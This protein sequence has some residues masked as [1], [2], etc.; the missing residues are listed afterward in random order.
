M[1]KQQVSIYAKIDDELSLA[2]D[3]K[4]AAI[5]TLNIDTLNKKLG[6]YLK[7]LKYDSSIVPPKDVA[8]IIS[9]AAVLE[10]FKVEA[11]KILGEN[12]TL[13]EEKKKECLHG[14]FGNDTEYHKLHDK[15][16]QHENG[17]VARV[18]NELKAYDI[19][20]LLDNVI[21][22]T[23][24][25][26]DFDINKN[27]FKDIAVIK[28]E[29]FPS[30]HSRKNV[31]ITATDAFDKTNLQNT[32][33]SLL[34]SD[35]KKLGLL[36][37]VMGDENNKGAIALEKNKE[38]HIDLNTMSGIGESAVRCLVIAALVLSSI[39]L[40][41]FIGGTAFF[42]ITTVLPG[43]A[44]SGVISMMAF[45]EIETTVSKETRFTNC[46][47]LASAAINV[48]GSGVSNNN[49]WKYFIAP[50]NKGRYEDIKD[51]LQEGI[52]KK[53]LSIND[54]YIKN[55]K[56][57]NKLNQHEYNAIKTIIAEPMKLLNCLGIEINNKTLTR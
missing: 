30:E 45:S 8:T 10:R 21:S 20:G 48:A 47:T 44:I 24:N 7:G 34:K 12:N 41:C 29:L 43:A 53:L 6:N 49:L 26:N 1:T 32:M 18:Q 54:V 15:Y 13:N 11:I 51:S 33:L 40:G 27:V 14:L 46:E 28:K 16:Y 39:Y 42:G 37:A 50:Y 23:L 52:E 25:K 19:E 38:W 36:F 3:L 9:N 55:D 22:K 31:F 4:N 5:N 17:L 35:P 2:A 56:V 57:I